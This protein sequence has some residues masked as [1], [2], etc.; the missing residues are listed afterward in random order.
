VEFTWPLML[1]A[2]LALPLLLGAY[3][4]AQRRRSKAAVAFSNLALLKQIAPRS[5]GWR[6]HVPAAVFF[7]AV[8]L[9]I[10]ALARPNVS[11]PVPVEL[12]YVVLAIDVSRS[13][14]AQDLDPSRM[15]AAKSGAKAFVESLPKKTRVGVV[16]FSD[17]AVAHIPPT[18]NH[19]LVIETIDKLGTV[20]GTAIGDGIVASLRILPGGDD[21]LPPNNGSP[22]ARPTPQPVVRA[23]ATIVLLSDG[24][25][26]LGVSPLAAAMD[27]KERNVKIYTVGIGS[28]R[29]GTVNIGNQ[30]VRV[31]LDEET[32]RRVASTTGGEY[33]FAP[34]AKDL[35]QVYK[36]LGSTL[37]WERQ[38]TEVT[39][40]VTAAALL[41]SV[42]GG[43]LSIL[44]FSRIL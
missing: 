3:V 30:T 27:A 31:L 38:L 14:E 15:E 34:T 17:R 22:N 8:A 41:L 12:S 5:S 1:W 25:S 28:Q 29:G 18:D 2:A 26:N 7:S 20:A 44:W 21:T 43:F 9:M 11:V 35:A 13:M 23:P 39:S 42:I 6:R 19:P 16:S 24:V 33:F 37:G 32:L 36:N 4:L 10:L 40:P